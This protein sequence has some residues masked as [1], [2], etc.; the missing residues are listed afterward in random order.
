MPMNAPSEEA[1]ED[2]HSL[3]AVLD[4]E[5]GEPVP[6]AS[7]GR[8]DSDRAMAPPHLRP[9]PTRPSLSTASWVSRAT[10]LAKGVMA[11]DMQGW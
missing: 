10:T 2:V 3:G 11:R 9:M 6:A 1:D 8:I 7:A 5:L 4:R